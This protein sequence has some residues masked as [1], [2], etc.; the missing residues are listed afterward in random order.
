MYR[1]FLHR[2]GDSSAAEDLTSETF[3]VAVR[4]LEDRRPAALDPWVIGVARHKLADHWRRRAREERLR[5]PLERDP[6]PNE[7]PWDVR[8][9]QLLTTCSPRSARTTGSRSRFGTWTD[10]PWPTWLSCWDVRPPP[11]RRC[12]FERDVPPRLPGRRRR[13]S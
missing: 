10:Y 12:W 3:L 1:Y 8:L 11:P 6:A 5:V 2:C 9:D 4:N 7:D 13:R